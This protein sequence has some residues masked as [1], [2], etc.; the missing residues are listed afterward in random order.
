MVIAQPSGK[1]PTTVVVIDDDPATLYS[2]SRILRA[3]GFNVAEA[4]TGRAGVEYARRGANLVVLD[5]NLPDIDGFEV[6]RQIRANPATARI[7]VIHLSASFVKD[8]DKV[9]G[10]EA[11]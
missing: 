6:C 3:A 4:D 10:L 11:G 8:A 1:Q 9:V 5:I 2:T 7:P